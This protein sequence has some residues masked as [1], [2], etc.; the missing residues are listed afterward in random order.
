MFTATMQFGLGE[1]VD[2]LREMVAR[3]AQDRI[4]PIAQEIDRTNQFPMELWK[5]MG[6]LGLLGV[7][8]EEEYGGV[9]LGY[10][11]HTIVVEELARTSASVSLSY[12]AHSN[13]CVNQ[14]RLNG[15]EEQRRKYLPRL[16]SGEHVGAL[17][18]SEGGAGSEPRNAT[19]TI[20]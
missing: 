8:V 18:M 6:E 19:T 5:E 15:T 11:A 7:T 16:V 1:E 3:W 9:G 20:A 4:A 2:A 12:G 13:L 14:I 17:A 10:L